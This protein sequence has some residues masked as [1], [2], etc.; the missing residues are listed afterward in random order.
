MVNKN[1]EVIRCR[2]SMQSIVKNLN[3]EFFAQCSVCYLVNMN[4]VKSLEKNIVYLGSDE[5]P[6]SRNY[7]RSFTDKF[8]DY[9]L[10]NGVI[11]N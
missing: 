7:K 11:R 5:L 1:V 6:L 10:N 9:M 8:M 3:S 4:H 2:G